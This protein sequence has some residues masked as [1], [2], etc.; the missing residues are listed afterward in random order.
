MYNIKI[1]IFL[2]KKKYTNIHWNK[3]ICIPEDMSK[4]SPNQ[5]I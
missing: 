4:Q 1:L 2:V 3:Q 5:T